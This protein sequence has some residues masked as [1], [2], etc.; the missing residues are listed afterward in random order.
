MNAV[1][2]L[3]EI[4]LSELQVLLS[5]RYQTKSKEIIHMT[6]TSLYTVQNIAQRSDI[7]ASTPLPRSFP[8]IVSDIK[9][10]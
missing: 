3:A 2:F 6:A 4:S 5:Y 8:F 9:L 7:N 10:N 1:Y